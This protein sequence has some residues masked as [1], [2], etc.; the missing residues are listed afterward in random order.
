[1]SPH[2]HPTLAKLGYPVHL[3]RMF[4]IRRSPPI[5]IDTVIH[6]MMA[7][8]EPPASAIRLPGDAYHFLLPADARIEILGDVRNIP[9]FVQE[10][11]DGKVL[12]KYGKGIV[13]LHW[14]DPEV[15]EG[16][17]W[18]MIPHGPK[19]LRQEAESRFEEEAEEKQVLLDMADWI[20]KIPLSPRVGPD[21]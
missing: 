6:N 8:G 5:Y 10:M 14:D 13:V 12:V 4:S 19:S 7:A 20:E 21:A 18:F 3:A 15:A 11:E 16:R 1:M 2:I 9:T 17:S